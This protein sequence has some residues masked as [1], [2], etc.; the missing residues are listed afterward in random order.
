MEVDKEREARRQLEE[1]VNKEKQARE[2]LEHE[3]EQLSVV[4]ART[5][6]DSPRGGH[7]QGNS[8]SVY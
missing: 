1:K 3:I 4:L 7:H 8:Q 2:N 6:N 5:E